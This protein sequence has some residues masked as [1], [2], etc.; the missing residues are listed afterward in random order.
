MTKLTNPNTQ[1]EGRST[2]Y[3]LFLYFLLAIILLVSAIFLI[4]YFFFNARLVNASVLKNELFVNED[5]LFT[6]NTPDAKSWLWEFGDGSRS[7]QQN[8]SHKYNSSGSYIVRLTVDDKL[9]A[10]YAVMVK[11]TVS[12]VQDTLLTVNGP[13]SGI[14]NE[15]IRFEAVG[16]GSL[17]EWSF[18]ESG[19]ID[20]KGKT[21]LYRFR[22]PGKYLIQLRNERNRP[23]NHLIYITDPSIDSV[24]VVPGEEDRI[25]IDDIRARLQ[26]I[27][28]GADFNS[29]YYYL[30]Q[31]YM[32]GNEKISVKVDQNKLSHTDDFYSYCMGLTFTKGIF[33]DKAELVT[34]PN[35]ACA[36]L[37]T[38]KQHSVE[39]SRSITTTEQ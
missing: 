30:V 18:G 28:D 11:D 34:S 8:G 7:S 2:L 22:N 6:D 3:H 1:T 26:A 31:S 9:S 20:A 37:L 23:A 17:F 16:P 5:L 39:K 15:E 35:A 19:R 33:I 38:V 32:C 14:T 12:I 13:T 25:I 4:R 24:L 36:T 27:A 10:Q 21:A 29:N